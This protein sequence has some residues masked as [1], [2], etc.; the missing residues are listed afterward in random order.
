MKPSTSDARTYRWLCGFAWVHA[1]AALVLLSFLTDRDHQVRPWCARAWA[2][3][4]VLWLLWLVVM[5]FHRG[6]SALRLTLFAAASLV[7]IVQC[8]SPDAEAAGE[9]LGLP[10]GVGLNPVSLLRY[11]NARQ[12]GRAEARRDVAAGV[13]AIEEYGFGAGTGDS[14]RILR[15]RY[16]IEERAIAQ[17]I[18]DEQI[19]G[20]AAGYNEVSEAEI[21]RRVGLQRVQAARVEGAQLA[22]EKTARQKRY[23][24]ELV[25]RFASSARDAKVMLESVQ[26]YVAGGGPLNAETEEQLRPIVRA[27]QDFVE[28]SVPADMPAFKLHISAVFDP[29]KPPQFETSGSSGASRP[30]YLKIYRELPR[31]ALPPWKTGPLSVALDFVVGSRGPASVKATSGTRSSTE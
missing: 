31:L 16:H 19:L 23:Y 17:C 7:L 11:Y 13:M 20:H 9:S 28:A 21:D 18:V 2:A 1:I 14:V 24:Q 6:R 26:P 15:E 22:A 4:M 29:G 25:A 5:N 12:A 10:P 3:T 30:V 8:L 27:I